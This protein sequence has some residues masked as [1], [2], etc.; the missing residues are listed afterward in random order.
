MSTATLNKAV[1][2]LTD[3]VSEPGAQ[4]KMSTLIKVVCLS[5]DKGSVKDAKKLN[6]FLQDIIDNDLPTTDKKFND[7]VVRKNLE[8]MNENLQK[9]NS[10][11]DFVDKTFKNNDEVEL[12][13]PLMLDFLAIME[14]IQKQMTFISDFLSL[15]LQVQN[16]KKSQKN[17]ST[18]GELILKLK[19]A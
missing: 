1:S 17:K 4:K 12:D 11:M 15:V 8:N 7:S 5:T 9:I 18:F 10:L 16:A 19:A 14:K 6:A 13:E 2:K 3:Y